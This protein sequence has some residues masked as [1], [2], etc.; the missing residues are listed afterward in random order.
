MQYKITEDQLKMLKKAGVKINETFKVKPETITFFYDAHLGKTRVSEN[1]ERL[2]IVTKQKIF[3]VIREALEQPAAM[4]TLRNNVSAVSV[5]GKAC[6]GC[7]DAVGNVTVEV[8]LSQVPVLI[9]I[10][11]GKS[12]APDVRTKIL[13]ELGN[14]MQIN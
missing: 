4:E 2:P 13:K 3:A 11:E 6:A 8:T 7:R 12:P 1:G 10:A 5:G 9:G 14:Y